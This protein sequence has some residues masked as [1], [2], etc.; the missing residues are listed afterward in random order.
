MNIATLKTRHIII[1]LIVLGTV[2]LLLPQ[3]T[4]ANTVM[5]SIEAVLYNIVIVV[6]GGFA[7]MGGVMLDYAINE[8]VLGFGDLY[9]NKGLGY[10]IDSLWV[11]VRDIFNLTFI[12]GLVFIGLRLIFDSSNSSARKTLI[13]LILAALLVNFSLFITKFIIDFSNIAVVQLVNTFP[14]G[15]DGSQISGSFMQIFGV[16]SLFGD[17]ALSDLVNKFKGFQG[18][19]GLLYIFSTMVVLL[20]LTFVFMAG[21]ILLMIRFVALNFYM[22]LSPL[23]F[24]GMVF[25]SAGRITQEFWSGFLGKA[26]FAP[27][28]ILMLYFSH[29]ILAAFQITGGGNL[30]TGFV[31]GNPIVMKDVLP[32]FILGAIFLIASL[33][34]AQKMGATGANGVISVGK[35]MSGKARNAALAPARKVAR[36]TA[37][38]VATEAE[39][40]NNYLQTTR[41]GRGLKR[42][43][44]VASLGTFTERERLA[45]IEAGKKSKFGGSYSYQDDKD[46]KK[47]TQIRENTLIAEKQRKQTLSQIEAD[48][49]NPIKSAKDLGD[50]LDSLSTLIKSMSKEEKEGLGIKK[51]SEYNVALN[52]SDSDIENLEKSGG[53]SATDIQTIKK[54]RSDA[55][56]AVAKEGNALH[57][58]SAH[59]YD[60]S[61]AMRQ[62]QALANR[63]TKDVGKMPIDIFKQIEMYDYITPSMVEERMRNG[64]TNKDL[65][66]LRRAI[67]SHLGIGLGVL[68]SSM[69]TPL[70]NSPWTKWEKSNST[71]AAQLFN[72]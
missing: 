16:T 17:A 8:M 40:A 62:R 38:T 35:M 41:S 22:L 67:E 59:K 2:S 33:V 21:A 44:S 65:Q 26:F 60:P 7:G 70:A 34:I 52:L 20:I 71:Y 56:I 36:V 57:A 25:P 63:G 24:A 43:V 53:Y 11:I 51:L 46:F 28:Y 6:F 27:A 55:Y 50:A 23:M 5:S 48:L 10:T 42:L 64:V 68:P 32:P 9:V 14:A 12:F 4:S 66:E 13:S 39:K 15:S 30:A 47:K 54:A 45:A 58:T 1:S 69:G 37:G 72:A 19:A 49:H 18:G 31:S 3:I 61:I 29:K